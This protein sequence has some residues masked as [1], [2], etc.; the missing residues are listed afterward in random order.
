[1][2]VHTDYQRKAICGIFGDATIG[3]VN[4][5]IANPDQVK[6]WHRHEKQT[7]RFFCL[8]GS[9]TFRWFKGGTYHQETLAQGDEKI[10]TIPPGYWHGYRSGPNGSTVLMYLD[11][12]YDELDEHRATE[13]ELGVPFP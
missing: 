2:R 9:I 3:D 11:R 4:V 5:F 8:A 10:V 13:L 1:M 6:C 12:K 7:D